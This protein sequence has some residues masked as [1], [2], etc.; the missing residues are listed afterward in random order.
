MCTSTLVYFTPHPVSW[1]AYK[2]LCS[3]I[4]SQCHTTY[5]PYTMHAQREQWQMP[6]PYLSQVGKGLLKLVQRVLVEGTLVYD[7]ATRENRPLCA[8]HCVLRFGLWMQRTVDLWWEWMNIHRPTYLQLPP[9]MTWTAGSLQWRSHL[10]RSL[11]VCVC[12]CAPLWEREKKGEYACERM[13][14]RVCACMYCTCAWAHQ[15]IILGHV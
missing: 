1:H 4:I 3:F 14:L 12:V 8:H 9:G 11:C 2:R 15:F 7:V 13:C 5:L 6:V 10:D